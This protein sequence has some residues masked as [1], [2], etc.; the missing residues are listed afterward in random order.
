LK[1]AVGGRVKFVVV[2]QVLG[3][4]GDVGGNGWGGLGVGCGGGG[5]RG[6]VV[7]W[8]VDL[9][10]SGAGIVVGEGAVGVVVGMVEKGGDGAGSEEGEAAVEASTVGGAAGFF[11]GAEEECLVEGK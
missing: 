6:R 8:A 1:K 7:I 4:A 5:V 3:V 11:E 10:G 9:E 2:G